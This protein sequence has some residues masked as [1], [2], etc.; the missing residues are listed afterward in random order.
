MYHTVGSW[1]GDDGDG[2]W[3]H[4][5]ITL[6]E[7]HLGEE[8][9]VRIKATFCLFFC[10]DENK[11]RVVAVDNVLIQGIETPE[12]EVPV[13]EPEEPA[14]TQDQDL[15]NLVAH[16]SV[17]PDSA[18]SGTSVKVQYSVKNTGT[19]RSGRESITVYR[20]LSETDNPE[21]GGWQ[22]STFT[23]RSPLAPGAEFS[24]VTDA[25]TPSV[26]EDTLVYYYACVSVAE[27][28]VQTDDNCDD[29]VTVTVKA[30]TT[31]TPEPEVPAEEP[32]E[33]PVE[34]PVGEP[35]E[36]PAEE[37]EE[38]PADNT[39]QIINTPADDYTEDSYPKP[40]YESCYDSPKRKHVM[41]GDAALPKPITGKILATTGVYSCGTIT[42]GG[43]ETKDGTKGFVM[44]NHVIAGGT[45]HSFKRFIRTNVLVGHGI[46]HAEIVES[47]Y[48]AY[49]ERLLGKVLK[50][51]EIRD[52]G[53]KYFDEYVLAADA[54]FV[55]YPRPKTAR[56]SLTWE[57]GGETFCL[58][59]GGNQIERVAPLKIRGR[60]KEVYTVVG[61]QEPEEGLALQMTGAVTGVNS[62]GR[63]ATDRKI[64]YVFPGN[65]VRTYSHIVPAP[66]NVAIIGDS[67]SP[68]YTAP[69]VNGSVR[70]V[71]I[72]IGLFSI[73]GGPG[74]DSVVFS[75]WDEVTDA[76]DLKP[77]SQ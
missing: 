77:I 35:T 16:I 36:T 51:S 23:M 43:V 60:G 50:G 30:K 45:L 40:P 42:L 15:P 70:I 74:V 29:P 66:E 39:K 31:E 13:E 27:G 59:L 54:A 37:P 18:N 57:S 38:V 73:G 19:A 10:G 69:D 72:L 61:S 62:I 65:T 32:E 63:M 25:E 4:N 58:D 11:E 2:V 1:D 28:E 56:C 22:I 53:G 48:T 17:S 44:S 52:V 6:D 8:T 12:P 71:G 20:H 49:I 3:H 33:T 9:T 68:I 75:S 41:A 5:T 34:T 14:D 47:A 67:G 26:S 24:Q 55:A 21:T 76:L 7:Q 64:L 46:S